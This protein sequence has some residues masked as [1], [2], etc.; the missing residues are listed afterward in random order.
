MRSLRGAH[1]SPDRCKGARKYSRG[2]V[3]TSDLCRV[4]RSASR[5]GE[6]LFIEF[7]A[8]QGGS[9]EPP[10]ATVEAPLAVAAPVP[11][12]KPL[13]DLSKVEE[14]DGP[15]PSSFRSSGPTVLD[16]RY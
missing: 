12:T 1:S 11:E 15:S 6:L 3:L 9:S 4:T 2:I 10:T 13:A 16:E 14:D 7:Q 8:S 5:N